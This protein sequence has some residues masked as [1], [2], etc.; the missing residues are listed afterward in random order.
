MLS[1]K[2]FQFICALTWKINFPLVSNTNCYDSLKIMQAAAKEIKR[3]LKFCR[4][5]VLCKISVI[6]SEEDKLQ[7]RRQKKMLVL[8][9]KFLWSTEKIRQAAA[10]ETKQNAGSKCKTSMI[11][12]E[13][14]LRA[15]KQNIILDSNAKFLWSTE[16]KLHPR[17]Q[18][19]MLDSNVKFLWYTETK[20]SWS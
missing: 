16:K 8:N 12:W 4:K 20:T 11:Y 13:D 6:Y 2:I 3:S 18:N 5:F 17:K 10:K 7:P 14:K 9:V 15:K 19:I 1:K